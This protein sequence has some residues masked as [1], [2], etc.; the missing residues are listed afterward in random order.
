MKDP[1][2]MYDY[3]VL[4]MKVLQDYNS[5]TKTWTLEMFFFVYVC[6][7][8]VIDWLIDVNFLQGH[9]VAKNTSL[10]L[11]LLKKAAAMV[12]LYSLVINVFA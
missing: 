11:Q 10:G 8:T 4:L 6:F 9:G 3:S 1:S 5:F 2:A 12:Q 7:L